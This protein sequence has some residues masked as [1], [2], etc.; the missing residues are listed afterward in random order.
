MTI[1]I[2][3]VLSRFFFQPD[4]HTHAR[5]LTISDVNRSLQEKAI[6]TKI[7]APGE[8]GRI[9][10]QATEWFAVCPDDIVLPPGTSVRVIGSSDATT[11]I[12]EP[13]PSVVS[14][15]VPLLEPA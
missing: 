6:V 4:S 13:L 2:L 7:I 9:S 10:F 12:I 14:C 1:P 15:S 3:T 8:K 5:I 11:L